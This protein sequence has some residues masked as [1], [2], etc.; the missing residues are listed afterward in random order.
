MATIG[1][2]RAVAEIGSIRFA[3]RTA[4]WIW[5]LIHIYYLIGFKNRLFVML[6]WAAS[7]VSFR[8]GARLIVDKEWRF[9]NDAS[10]TEEPAAPQ[11]EPGS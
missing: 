6:Q 10:E 11:N 2:S 4:W 3:G 9:Y 1:R 7:F 8:R 5:V